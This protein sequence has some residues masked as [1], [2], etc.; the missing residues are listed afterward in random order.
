[1]CP[2]QRLVV[3][4][5]YLA[6]GASFVQL[7]YD[8]FLGESTVRYVVHDTCKAIAEELADVYLKVPSTPEEWISIADG[9]WTSWNLP[10]CLGKLTE[11]IGV[12]SMCDYRQCHDRFR[13]H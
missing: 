10:N 6:T 2:E 12:L 7:G 1:M 11:P 9:F 8:F 4:L 5:K 13:C 3:T